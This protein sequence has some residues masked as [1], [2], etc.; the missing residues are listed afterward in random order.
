MRVAVL[1][2]GL[3]GSEIVS[4]TGWE[5]FS[6]KKDR[7]DITGIENWAS[8]L[9]SPYDTIVNCIAFT[10]TYS[11]DRSTNWDVNV[12]A[13][14]KLVEYCNL[15]NKTLVHISTDY[16]YTGSDPNAS[17][18]SVPVHLPTWYGYTKL[19][20]D[21]IVQLKSN[22]YLICRLSHKPTP[23]PY[24][25]AWTDINTNCDYVDVIASLVIKLIKKQ[26]EGIYN[27]GTE[28]KT[29]YEL[30][31][32]TSPDVLPT[33]KPA[34]VPDDTTMDLSKLHNII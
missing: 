6:R 33:L 25:S 12:V 34:G 17:E 15:T 31:K 26:C 19:V 3:L 5:F 8:K 11:T 23:F 7:L 21:A 13:V 9:L 10:K 29:M 32:Q 28:V 24:S 30:A 4:Q 20:G 18:D 27:V 14:E 1:G 2:D 22:R 16:L